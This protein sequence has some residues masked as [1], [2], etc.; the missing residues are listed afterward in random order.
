MAGGANR[1]DVVGK[2]KCPRAGFMGEQVIG[3]KQG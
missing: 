3:K 1:G 2:K